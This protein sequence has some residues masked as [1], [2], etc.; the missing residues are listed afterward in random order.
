MGRDRGVKLEQQQACTRGV[1][2]III[3]ICPYENKISHTRT[4]PSSL[5]M[6]V[7]TRRTRARFVSLST[8]LHTYVPFFVY[9]L[10]AG[11]RLLLLWRS[12]RP[13][14]SPCVDGADAPP[15]EKSC[16]QTKNTR[17]YRC[18]AGTGQCASASL[19]AVSL[20][21]HTYVVPL[22]HPLAFKNRPPSDAFPLGSRLPTVSLRSGVGPCLVVAGQK[23]AAVC[24]KSDLCFL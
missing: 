23:T 21:L 16:G 11:P 8:R 19:E 3:A 18:E 13:T 17:K 12:L 20:L 9:I 5:V 7:L 24:G 14:D 1:R 10:L 2:T 6:Y 15:R 22:S 4:H